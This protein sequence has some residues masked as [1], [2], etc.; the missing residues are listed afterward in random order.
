MAGTGPGARRPLLGGTPTEKYRRGTDGADQ[1]HHAG[2]TPYPQRGQQSPAGVV[3][4]NLEALYVAGQE[5]GKCE[6]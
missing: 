1:R 4:A 3:W 6:R 2:R 5:F